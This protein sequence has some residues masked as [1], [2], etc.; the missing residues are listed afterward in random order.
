[1]IVFEGIALGLGLLLVFSHLIERIRAQPGVV[2][3]IAAGLGF[4]ISDVAIE[5]ALGGPRQRA[6]RPPEP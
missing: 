5:S 6:D 4:G 3:G 2:L 1:M